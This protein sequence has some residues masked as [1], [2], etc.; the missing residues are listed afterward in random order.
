[1]SARGL[2][3]KGWL[4]DFGLLGG[5][6][7]LNRSLGHWG[8][9]SKG[10]AG[11]SLFFFAFSFWP[12]SEQLGSAT[13]PWCAAAHRTP[14]QWVPHYRVEPPKQ[15]AQINFFSSEAAYNTQSW[16][17]HIRPGQYTTLWVQLRDVL[18]VQAVHRWRQKLPRG[19]PTPHPH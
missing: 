18:P 19:L 11:P 15:S 4:P 2:Y 14:K 7:T 6:G 13:L 16:H 17:T 1:M 9:P 10:T 3:I 5:S 8:V 12:G